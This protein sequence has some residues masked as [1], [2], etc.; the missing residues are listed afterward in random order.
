MVGQVFPVYF[1]V[2]DLVEAAIHCAQQ[3][4]VVFDGKRPAVE[5]NTEIGTQAQ[6]VFRSVRAVMR[7]SEGLDMR[8]FRVGTAEPFNPD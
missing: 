5:Q 8:A 4:G 6:N 3:A 7:A 1:V 2:V